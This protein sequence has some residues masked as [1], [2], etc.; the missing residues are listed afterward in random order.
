MLVDQHDGFVYGNP[1]HVG[2]VVLERDT[3]PKD[4][5]VV[6]DP[7][8][9]GELLST[10]KQVA[11]KAVKGD[12]FL[13]MG[14][15]LGEV[16]SCGLY[17]GAHETGSLQICLKPGELRA[18]VTEFPAGLAVSTFFTSCLSGG[19]MVS[20]DLKGPEE[21][22]IASIMAAVKEGEKS[23]SSWN[24]SISQRLGG[25]I[26]VSAMLRELL[27]EIRR[28][29]PV[30]TYQQLTADVKQTFSM[31]PTSDSRLSHLFAAQE[32]CWADLI[33]ERTGVFPSRYSD[34]YNELRMIAPAKMNP[35]HNRGR[36]LDD[37]AQAAARYVIGL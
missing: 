9:K 30:E 11:R 24:E 7:M 21:T 17:L 6:T 25:S 16:G 34:W 37:I 23:S 12:E 3:I 4:M 27:K 33:Q 13:I 29:L 10:V 31:R 19:W 20:Q 15:A 35:L 18:A 22:P 1:H 5:A 36:G 28:Q 26:Y 32:S 2:R 8:L 14:F